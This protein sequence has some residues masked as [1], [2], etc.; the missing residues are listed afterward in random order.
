M[1]FL[2]Q[3]FEVN[4]EN[5]KLNNDTMFLRSS[6]KQSSLFFVNDQKENFPKSEKS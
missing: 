5:F 1:F 6:S 3:L 4:L 2:G